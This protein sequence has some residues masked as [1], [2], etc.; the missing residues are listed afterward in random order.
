MF[1][2]RLVPLVR[3]ALWIAP[4]AVVLFTGCNSEEREQVDP[5]TLRGE[6]I[7]PPAAAASP[8][9]PQPPSPDQA[10]SEL[11]TKESEAA[12]ASAAPEQDSLA[13]AAPDSN[14]DKNDTNPAPQADADGF[15]PLR[16]DVLSGYVI[17][18]PDEMLMSPLDTVTNQPS[19]TELIPPNVRKLDGQLVSLEGF[20]LP[21][22]VEGGL[23]TELL[24]M[25]DQSQCCYGVIPK[26]NE[27]VSVR[28]EERG[29]KPL[30]DVP[31]T[32]HGKLH[33]GPMVENGYLV[34]I[35]SMDGQRMT[36]PLDD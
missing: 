8:A 2:A 7:A 34:G 11:A 27:W 26:I 31:V 17:N 16:F 15:V 19:P 29:V 12:P 1:A 18:I 13:A 22:K 23:V 14:S 30:M 10:P 9:E 25:K 20:M 24:L 32:L 5:L 28:L 4:V 36:G 3:H 6:P 35:Y 21:L 33:V